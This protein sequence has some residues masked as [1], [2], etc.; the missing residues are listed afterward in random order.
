M[1]DGKCLILVALWVNFPMFLFCTFLVLHTDW[2]SVIDNL[3]FQHWNEKNRYNFFTFFFLRQVLAI[4]PRLAPNSWSYCL[5]L[6]NA[7]ITGVYL[8]AQLTLNILSY[9]HFLSYPLLLPFEHKA[10]IVFKSCLSVAS[11]LDIFPRSEA[12]LSPGSSW[13]WTTHVISDTVP[14]G[15]CA[16]I[17]AVG[18]MQCH[19]GVIVA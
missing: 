8:H 3:S 9:K 7:G 10:E 15:V 14:S 17:S 4:L 12:S 18:E 1:I 2:Y 19:S 11:L 13:L 16:T 6:L 5:S